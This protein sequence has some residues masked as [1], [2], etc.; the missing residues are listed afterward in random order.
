MAGIVIATPGDEG[1][2]DMQGVLLVSNGT[3]TRPTGT[4]SNARVVGKIIDNTATPPARPP[5][6][7][8][9]ATVTNAGAANGSWVFEGG[10]PG[11]PAGNTYKLVVWLD[12]EDSACFYVAVKVFDAVLEP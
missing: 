3:W 8:V 6:D 1:Y 2:V 4:T 7:T 10:L 11:A 9:P 12:V 5:M